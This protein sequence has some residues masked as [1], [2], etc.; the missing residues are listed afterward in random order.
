MEF[1]FNMKDNI[2]NLEE[3]RNCKYK[4]KKGIRR[5]P[6]CGILNPTVKTK[7]IFKTIFIVVII[8]SIFTYFTNN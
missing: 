8:M 6:A 4:V 3:C 2:D 1:I 7:D 5:C